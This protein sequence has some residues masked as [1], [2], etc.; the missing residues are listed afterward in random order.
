MRHQ[1]TYET[2]EKN[3][4]G[5]GF[6]FLFLLLTTSGSAFAQLYIDPANGKT[7]GGCTDINE[8]CT[9]DHAF[10]LSGNG[11]GDVFLIRVRRAGGG[12]TLAAP[13]V[14]LDKQFR[15]GAY[16][17][18]NTTPV[19]GTIQFTGT[20]TI[21]A[22]GE[23]RLDPNASVQF[24]DVTLSAGA[25][26]IPFFWVADKSEE[27]I[28][29]TGTLT[30]PDGER[31]RLPAL[32]VSK[33][34]T[35]KGGTN[36][37]KKTSEFRVGGPPGTGG[38]P[39]EI[40]LT[41]HRGATLRI[42][43]VDLVVH[44]EKEIFV[45]GV[46]EDVTKGAK[47]PLRI[48]LL[49][50]TTGP[51]NRE[52]ASLVGKDNYQP[53]RQGFD[54]NDCL[55][56][57][58]TGMIPAGI[59]AISMGNLCVEL[60]RVGLITA[61]GS[62]ANDIFDNTDVTTDLIFREDVVVDGDVVQWND[63]R[64]L[65]AKTATIRGDVILRDGGTPY[66]NTADYGV[67][68]T[69][70][71]SGVRVGW[72][73]SN[74]KYTCEYSNAVR[75]TYARR[76]GALWTQ[77]IPG[78]HFADAVT[79]AGDLNVYSNTLTETTT[80]ATKDA[81]QCAPRVLFMAPL[82]KTSGDKE[83][84]LISSVGGSLVVEDTVS[85]GGKGRVYL[86]SDSAST[87]DPTT[88]VITFSHR[89]S[90]SLRVGGDLATGGKT[91]GMEY[92]A[93]SS[94]D[95]M[96][97]VNDIKLSFG[98]H[99][100]LT[101][102]A[103][104]VVIGDA[105]SGLTLGAL[106]TLGDLRV[107]PGKGPLTVTTLH[108]GPGAEL[109]ANK[110]VKVTESLILQGE[111]S[112]ELDEASTIKTLTYGSRNT[113][114]VKKAAL[115]TMLEALSISVGN[116][117]LRLDEVYKTKHLGLCSGT[118]SLVDV[119]STTDSTLHVTDQI[120]VQ[121]GMLE[122][123]TNNP[124]S[125]STDKA[126]TVNVNDRYLLKYITPGKRTVTEKDL[127]WFD[128]R[129]VIV[130]HKDAEITVNDD[131][132]IIG[133][134]TI[135]EGTLMV[136]GDL[137]VGTSTLHRTANSSDDT[138]DA[139][140]QVKR[141]SIM[142]TAG[143]LHT[144]EKDVVVYGQVTVSNKSK[145]MTGGGDLHVLGRVSGGA[146]VSKTAQ[147]TVDKDA[148]MDLGA[149]TLH[150][151]PEDTKK[152]NGLTLNASLDVFLSL[153]G[154]LKGNVHVPK[155][156]KYTD[157][158]SVS[159]LGTVTFDGTRTPN[160]SGPA[161]NTYGTLR[162]LLPSETSQTLVMDSL[163]AMQGRVITNG[164]KVTINADVLLESATII[165]YTRDSLVFG[166]DLTLR[167]TGGLNTEFN[168]NSAKRNVVI[169]GNFTQEP[170]RRDSTNLTLSGVKLHPMTTK[171]VLGDV[172]V[173]SDAYRYE[174]ETTTSAM[175]TLVVHGDFHFAK[176]SLRLNAKVE[177]QGK[178]V[179]EVMIGDTTALHSIVV[180]NPKGLALQSNVTQ[181]RDAT[182]TLRRG[183]IR[184]MPMDSI[185]TWTVR[186]VQGERELRGR[187]SAQE[188]DKCG[189]DNG[190]PC[191]G[192]ILRG[193]SQS[194]V[195]VPV[196]RHL[197]QGTAGAGFE[198]GGYLFPVG[199]E[200]GEVSHYRP[201]I[202]QLPS[203][204]NDTT[205]VTVSPILVPDGVMPAWPVEN[206]VVPA[207]G[208][209][210]TLDVHANL[211]WKIDL[212]AEELPTNTNIRLVAEGIRNVANVTGLRIV[213]WDCM[214]K[215]PKLAGGLPAQADASSFGVNGYLNGVV[216]LTQ[217]G[218]GLGSCA[219]L[220]IAAS[221]IENPI[222]QADLSAGRA[223]LQFIHNL[224]LTTP[225]ELHLGRVRISNNLRFRDATA[226]RPVSTGSHELKIQPV[227]APAEQ[228][229]TYAVSLTPNENLVVIAHGS[230]ADPKLKELDMRMVSSISNKVDVRLVH[231]SADLGAAQ[232]QVMD[233][234][235]PMM[236]V[237]TLAGNLMLDEATRRYFSLDPSVQV[238]QVRSVEQEVKEVYELDLYKYAGQTLVWNLSGT[239]RDLTILG[240]DR[241]GGIVPVQ[242]VTGVE[243]EPAEI[244][245]EFALHGNYPNPFNPSTRIQFDLPE[246]AQVYVQIVDL[247]GREVMVLPAQ[248]MEAGTNRSIELNAIRLASGTYLYRLIAGG[249]KARHVK[250]G[251]MTLVK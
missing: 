181:Q 78:V 141:Y 182:L 28:A 19:K 1:L 123:D 113:D 23:F 52:V 108:V 223:N 98:N 156:S 170:G 217:E 215:N 79:I 227:G 56:I 121:N 230:L 92:P 183:K 163:S 146:Y 233:S 145:L 54:H 164:K 22:A 168:S 16:V 38:G 131:R 7:T 140:K 104:S 26:T 9:L 200:E 128:L 114:V 137:T 150:L 213:Q 84:A 235:N 59:F 86:D 106:V 53:L 214:W 94:V 72:R 208:G 132:L 6:L 236:P 178:E 239:K 234:N 107:E 219:I 202:L 224:P 250:T 186:N 74:S 66:T 210:L 175:P 55:R 37:E 155:G 43:G 87:Q 100:M 134:L 117:E 27:R 193:S 36:A 83:I 226:Y 237:M 24:E 241:N 75:R 243:T 191:Q 88:N 197:L 221:G 49:N 190:E 142:V 71:D 251:R 216:N 47:H 63:S 173:S 8:P 105:T 245:K 42:D 240:V 90:H 158:S 242:T 51:G 40:P 139:L 248:E 21:A 46:I 97:T 129:D 157:I 148:V 207:T 70:A 205:A 110:D 91:I 122:R 17:Q 10:S 35:V 80:G 174:M 153:S 169:K 126:K 60:K 198:S 85:F 13:T 57:R 41:V 15:F 124:G 4:G 176:D 232:V 159:Q 231:G 119:E 187:L 5:A 184:S 25:R 118:L 179:Q 166:G 138:Q 238:V 162:F 192:T 64:I 58:G 220:G 29:I 228:A 246:Q 30:I 165:P 45:E 127:E 144:R 152:R 65:F 185:Y 11:N 130:D 167:G 62:L 222:D 103:E 50:S 109:M 229:I 171:T 3:G 199:T 89:T 212:G 133:S 180:D 67:A 111:L 218:V 48:A 31:V 81:T 68:N 34:F 115:V 211:F 20:F 196:V 177:F 149:G 172:R 77:Y 244:P 154:T 73:V 143:E 12:V 247:L 188:G 195:G 44:L 102:A 206:L 116:G 101:D 61:S 14:A 135:S 203:D 18:G 112:G 225:V 32:V 189:A 194:Y 99:L 33:G 96:C 136:D 120:M 93:T 161:E 160:A 201:L 69:A 125:I 151:G 249:A 39:V 147:V 204:L 209:S 2:P 95:G 76:F 82:A